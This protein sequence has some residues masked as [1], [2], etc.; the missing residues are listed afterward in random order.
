VKHIMIVA[1]LLVVARA[2]HAQDSKPPRGI[3]NYQVQGFYEG[4]A[5]EP[6]VAQTTVRDTTVS[7]AAALSITYHTRLGPSGWVYGYSAI[8]PASGAQ[9]FSKWISNGR[10]P[11]TCTAVRTSD[12][13]VADMEALGKATS[14]PLQHLAVPDFALATVLAARSL[15]HRDSIVLHVFR[16]S[17]GADHPIVVHDLNAT[18]STGT[19]ARSAGAQPEAVWLINGDASFPYKAIIAKSDGQVLKVTMPQGSVGEMIEVYTSPSDRQ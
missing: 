1:A 4:E 15:S 14:R 10:M 2:G 7:K 5:M 19:H 6:W 12:R 3:H 18:V 13:I 16:C 9:V 17:P 11:S 8:I